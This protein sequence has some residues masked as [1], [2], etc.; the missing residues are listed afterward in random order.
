M[1]AKTYSFPWN[2]GSDTTYRAWGS[3][4]KAA[5]LDIGLVQTTDT[6]QVDWTTV[7]SPAAGTLNA[8]EI[9]RFSDPLQ[10][11]APIFIKIEYGASSSSAGYP[12]MYVTMG[13]ATNGA[14]SLTG[15]VGYRSLMNASTAANTLAKTTYLAMGPGYMTAILGA[16]IGASI[17]PCGV[18]VVERTVNPDGTY[19]SAGFTYAVQNHSQ[20]QSY[21]VVPY[22]TPPVP[23]FMSN[24]P[25]VLPF[26]ATSNAYSS[27]AD[28]TDVGFFSVAAATPRPH[29]AHTVCLASTRGDIAR[30]TTFPMT[31]YGEVRN[32]IAMG[33]SCNGACV[34]G[35]NTGAFNS[36]GESSWAIRHD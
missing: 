22:G 7:T 26:T 15:K 31:L 27:F 29:S 8:Y 32:F 11:T 9:Y 1:T 24:L 20:F 17:Y 36:L 14:G 6:G 2:I 23:G 35:S 19:N 28:G 30:Y 3:S 21:S 33:T 34:S 12:W 5:L 13:S 25:V 4:V 10:A 18:F 16:D